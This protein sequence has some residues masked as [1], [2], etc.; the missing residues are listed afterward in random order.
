MDSFISKHID[1]FSKATSS[2]SATNQ[3]GQPLSLVAGIRNSIEMITSAD[4]MGNTIYF[5]GNGGSASICSHMAVDFWKTAGIKAQAFTDPSMLTCIGNDYGYSQIF[6]KPLEMFI[7]RNDIL[8]AISSSGKS[9]NILNGV[10]AARSNG[11][12]V[13]TMS[14]FAAGNPLSMLGDIN[15]YVP[16]SHYGIVEVTH[17]LFCHSILDTINR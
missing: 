9:E 4:S 3:A 17:A 1:S 10:K 6:Q 16:Y 2:S 7:T 11:A 8:I 5:I 13:I 15:F 12:L 14:G